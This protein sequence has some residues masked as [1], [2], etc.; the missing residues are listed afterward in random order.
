MS[1]SESVAIVL[2]AF[3]AVEQRDEQRLFELYHPEVEFHWPPSLPFGGS[4]RGGVRDRAGP[5]WSEVWAPLQPTETER[6]MDPRVVAATENEVVV[7]WH[8]RAISPAGS[9]STAKPSASTRFETGNSLAR[10]CSTSTPSPSNASWPPPR[11]KLGGRRPRVPSR[12]EGPM[13]RAIDHRHHRLPQR[14]NRCGVPALPRR[15]P[16]WAQVASVIGQAPRTE[17]G[18]S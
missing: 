6:R 11:R 12:T 16:P 4:A 5:S 9:A 15:H 10:R 18:H 7:Q 13:R 17:N 8:Q 1:A 3:T 14:G 2:A